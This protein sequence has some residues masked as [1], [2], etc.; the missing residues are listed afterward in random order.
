MAVLTS[1]VATGAKI[2]IVGAIVAALAVGAFL[3]FDS[4]VDRTPPG[5]SGRELFVAPDGW[6]YHRGT[7]E[8]PLD[9]A[10]A[11]SDA[12][13]VQPGD[14]V[15][16][17]GGVYRGSVTSTLVGEPDA[18]IIVRAYPGERVTL[19]A[20]TQKEPTLTVK[21]SDTWFWG[22]E[23]TDSHPHRTTADPAYPDQF[24]ATSVAVYG[25]R[26]KF[27]NMVVHDGE[28][29]FGLW[30]GAVDAEL[31]GNLIF[32]VGIEAGGTGHGHSV[33]VQNDKGVKRIVDN[34]M[35]N[36]HS[37]GVHAYTE[38]GQ[39]NNV[40][41]EGNTAFNHG[42]L[43]ASGPKANF[44]IRSK[45]VAPENPVLIGNYAYS[46]T[47]QGGRLADLTTPVPG[48]KGCTN[49]VVRD[50]YF[51]GVD[52]FALAITCQ[53]IEAIRGNTFYGKVTGIAQKDYPD[54]RFVTSRPSGVEVFARP[55]QY[56]A[57]RGHVT[58]FNWDRRSMVAVR[59]TGLGLKSGEW[60]EI[61]DA[62]NY[63][64][65]PVVVAQYRPWRR[66]VIDMSRLVAAAP[67]GDARSAAHTAPEFGVFV[68]SKASAESDRN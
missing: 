30:T 44:L 36:G 10:S 14:I 35:F 7:R 23:V 26:T 32:N 53:S 57:G 3:G 15:W 63:F 17:R 16:I 38:Q 11:L 20:A 2:G 24:R 22:L 4:P 13:R 61:R 21:G 48:V 65:P 19:D 6:P 64:G 31:Y 58:V 67:V 12:R 55:N 46:A 8:E 9:L 47:G 60:Y 27:I 29:G 37:F 5:A 34:I 39:L 51:A 45:N 54:N 33:Y 62:Q 42:V 66:A 56:E 18:P 28:Q 59:L 1:L 52:A 50:N 41:L 68:V 43:A 25:P 49:A 40:H